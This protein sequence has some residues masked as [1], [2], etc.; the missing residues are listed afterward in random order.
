MGCTGLR[1]V[2]TPG[3]IVQWSSTRKKEK[4]CTQ[5]TATR[6]L[7]ILNEV[8]KKFLTMLKNEMVFVFKGSFLLRKLLSVWYCLVA[9]TLLSH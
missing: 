8:A 6:R 2:D 3:L 5:E 7:K 1:F 4:F 9:W